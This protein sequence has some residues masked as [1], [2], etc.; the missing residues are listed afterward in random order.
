MNAGSGS[1]TS[2]Y[3]SFKFFLFVRHVFF[4]VFIDIQIEKHSR[5]FCFTF[6][7]VIIYYWLNE[8]TWFEPFKRYTHMIF[9][10]KI[11]SN[12]HCIQEHCIH[13]NSKIF[14][15]NANP[16]NKSTVMSAC[17]V[18]VYMDIVKLRNARWLIN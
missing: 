4:I 18:Y 8:S 10:N 7:R 17:D 3:L 11:V 5:H 15:T 16:S 1:T 6:Q 2:H 13:Q 9:S 14:Q 12:T